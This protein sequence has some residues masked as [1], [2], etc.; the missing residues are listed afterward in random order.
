MKNFTT[1]LV[2]SFNVGEDSVRVGL[3]QFSSSFQHEFYLKDL[4]THESI[5]KHILGM[6]QL[7]GG[8]KIG[9]ALDSIREFFE[10]SNGGRRSEDLSQNLV[11]ITDGES[12]DEVQDAADRLRALGVEVFVIGIG[13][14]HDMQLLQIT[15]RRDRLFT[16]QN[17]KSMESIKQ[18]VVTTICKSKPI[19]ERPGE[20]T[21]FTC[22][23]LPSLSRLSSTVPLR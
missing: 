8:T 23:S 14:V 21:G 9:L 20:L 15:G 4:Y 12:Q 5:T 11:L 19:K 13:N 1:Q 16:V 3:A 18:K 17:F 22:A 6:K 7:G 2:S 10:A